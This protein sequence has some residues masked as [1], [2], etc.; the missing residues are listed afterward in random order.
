MN[1]KIHILLSVVTFGGWLPFYGAF[2]LYY[3]FAESKSSDQ[4]E[5]K[6]L[7][8]EQKRI[9]ETLKA[10]QKALRS[11]ARKAFLEQHA[12][13]QAHKSSLGYKKGKGTFSSTAYTLECSH[14]IRAKTA[15]KSLNYFQGKSVYCEICKVER[16]VIGRPRML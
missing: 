6:R 12:Q 2:Y 4:S 13:E 8:Q 10:D 1:H 5:T 11:Q 3:K 9:K 15:S 16:V 7:K 14:M